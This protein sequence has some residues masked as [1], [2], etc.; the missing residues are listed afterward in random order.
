MIVFWAEFGGFS[1]W[2]TFG[3]LLT[4]SL[5]WDFGHISSSFFNVT[6]MDWSCDGYQLV[7]IIRNGDND[8]TE[9]MQLDFIK[10][11]LSVNPSVSLTPFLLL[12][13]DDKVFIN[14][15]QTLETVYDNTKLKHCNGDINDEDLEIKSV[16]GTS[17]F[18]ASKYW[19]TVSAPTAYMKTNWPIRFSSL[20]KDGV[21]LAVAGKAGIALYSLTHNKW[22]LFGNEV[23]EKDFIV[24]SGLVWYNEFAIVGNY[25]LA[26]QNDEI[27]VYSRNQKLE[28]SYASIYEI[29]VPIM[30]INICEDQL[31]VFTADSRITIFSMSIDEAGEAKDLR[32]VR[33]QVY[34]ITNICL[35]PAFVV[36]I[37]LTN[38]KLD[39]ILK[40]QSNEPPQTIIINV[41]GR[42]LMI[43]KD[44]TGSSLELM[45]T[46]LASCVECIWFF[47]KVPTAT[48]NKVHL[49]ESLWLHCGGHGMRVWLPVFPR[50][51]TRQTN[52]HHFMAKRI[53]LS[54]N[55]HIYPLAISF[56][57]AIILGIENDTTLFINDP[58]SHFALPFSV[59]RRT[60]QV[61]LHHLLKQLIRRNL[62]Y[63]A[64]DIARS[65]SSLPY[66]PHSLE[67]LLHEVLEQEATSKDPIPD[68]LMPS[69]IEFIQE[70][71]C[72]LQTV[73]Q[74]AR[75]TEIA[76]W[77]YLFVTAGKPR[78]LFQSC[79]A[80]RQLYTATNYLIIIQNLEPSSISKQY[81]MILLDAALEQKNWCLSHELV[82]FFRAI[83]TN[84]S[85]S[86]RNS[87][88]GG[89]NFPMMN[90]HQMQPVNPDVDE[91]SLIMNHITPRTP[92][93]SISAKKLEANKGQVTSAPAQHH[94]EIQRRHTI[95]AINSTASSSSSQVKQECV[96]EDQLIDSIILK[97]LKK[98]LERFELISL[99]FMSAAMDVQL[100]TWLCKE[101]ER[102]TVPKIDDF[103]KA[104]KLLLTHLGLQKSTHPIQH[105]DSWSAVTTN[106]K[107]KDS[108]YGSVSPH[109]TTNQPIHPSAVRRTTDY[110][111]HDTN[112]LPDANPID[113]VDQASLINMSTSN[114]KVE[115]QLRYLL[116]IFFEADC[117]DFSL[118]IS[119]LLL[120]SNSVARICNAALRLPNALLV[121]RQLR[122]GLKE[123]TRWTLH[124]CYTYRNFMLSCRDELKLLEHF[125][126]QHD[127][128]KDA[129]TNS[130]THPMQNNIMRTRSLS[131]SREDAT[132]ITKPTECDLDSTADNTDL[133]SCSYIPNIPPRPSTQALDEFRSYLADPKQERTSSSCAIM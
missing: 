76:L 69:V 15:S 94:E 1:L 105:K 19:I 113:Y 16:Q 33:I 82:R 59:F 128:A 127:S 68:A 96:E 115:I 58:T 38:L 53:M 35:H 61:Y 125:V 122:K 74:C 98:Y 72:Y 2:S 93:N 85:S 79:M 89:F 119:V 34:D 131:G 118:L 52:K 39:N 101:K 24:T 103:V 78:E 31:I 120:D 44:D 49:K 6:S 121:A 70:F 25:N 8:Q 37:F 63:N 7:L 55:L 123:L 92:R 64:W 21:N 77:P 111:Q 27:R 5:A 67:L 73:V 48:R 54:F 43:Q 3:A 42:V 109:K 110:N 133:E 106:H 23:Q 107:C 4:C 102:E 95:G 10:S 18:S 30:L 88:I 104:L 9:L 132:S 14:N 130:T 126:S 47:N 112:L 41:A 28:N 124:E 60:S 17:L 84:E 36:S 40:T 81:A 65:C 45:T 22:K 57:D 32:L 12:Q 117:F 66:F 97:H 114:R 75:K 26:N 20:D 50:Q 56:D 80:H 87:Y 13:G 62:G 100:V 86:P 83:D 116:Q 90:Q 46:C 51:D 71:P 11:A 91:L 129:T 29:S 108:G 99:G